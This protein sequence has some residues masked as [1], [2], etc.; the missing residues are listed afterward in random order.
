MSRLCATSRRSPPRANDF[1]RVVGAIITALTCAKMA[2][3][4]PRPRPRRAPSV[5]PYVGPIPSDA[6]PATVLRV[7]PAEHFLFARAASLGEDVY[8]H[9]AL[10]GVDHLR[11]VN[12]IAITIERSAR[13]LR[14]RAPTPR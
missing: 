2:A 3:M 9:G 13:G 6:V 12:E 10:F 5:R 1:T 7:D 11:P 14:A 8:V 4:V